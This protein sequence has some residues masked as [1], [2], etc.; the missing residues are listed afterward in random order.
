[1]ASEEGLEEIRKRKYEQMLQ[2]Q[3][4]VAA[5]EERKQEIKEAKKTIIRQILTTEARERLN[6]IRTAKPEFAEQLENQ[7]I[8]LAQTGRLKGVIND[9]QL[10]ELLQQI[11]PKKREISITRMG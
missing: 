6:N 11:M 5:E 3:A 9:T 2:S 7:L 1:M 10:K 4:G 8:A